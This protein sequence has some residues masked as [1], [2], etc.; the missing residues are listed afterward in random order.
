M[1][2]VPTPHY[3]INYTELQTVLEKIKK[4]M[5]MMMT[6]T[7]TTTTTTMTGA[8]TVITNVTLLP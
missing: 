7:T 2:K 5:M 4:M 8:R 3:G 6:T 1:A